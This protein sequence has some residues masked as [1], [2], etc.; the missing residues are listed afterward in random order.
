MSPNSLIERLVLFVSTGT[1][2][3][4]SCR[5]SKFE[6]RRRVLPSHTMNSV[7]SALNQEIAGYLHAPELLNYYIAVMTKKNEPQVNLNM[8]VAHLHRWMQNL[9]NKRGISLIV[10]AVNAPV[11]MKLLQGIFHAINCMYK[12]KVCAN[13]GKIESLGIQIVT[14]YSAHKGSEAVINYKINDEGI[15]CIE[16]DGSSCTCDECSKDYCSTCNNKD[17]IRCQCCSLT[18]CEKCLYGNNHVVVKCSNCPKTLC[19]SCSD[20]FSDWRSCDLC[21]RGELCDECV[22]QVISCCSLCGERAACEYCKVVSKD[23]YE[24]YLDTCSHCDSSFCASVGSSIY[25]TFP[26]KPHDYLLTHLLA[27][28]LSVMILMRD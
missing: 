3:A 14:S 2:T 4:G 11:T 25:I 28:L 27:R 7:V 23:A 18:I 1:G 13:N 5:H 6:N 9:A 16:A 20:E 12:C 10:G 21:E 17:F 19:D 24:S 8:N 22:D 26:F 15:G